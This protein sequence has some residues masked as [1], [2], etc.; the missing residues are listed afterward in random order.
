MAYLSEGDKMPFRGRAIGI[1]LA[2]ATAAALPLA[3]QVISTVAS[4]SAWGGPLDAKVD[5]AGNMYVA[6]WGGD[7]IYKVDVQGRMTVIAGMRV[8]RAVA[9][10][11][12]RSRGPLH[13]QSHQR[14]HRDA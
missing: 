14:A 7:A 11:S 3:S 5:G 1:G 9:G 6:D 12:T 4:N 8:E 2:L 10:L 13:S